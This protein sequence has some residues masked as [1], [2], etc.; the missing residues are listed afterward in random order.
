VD[1]G[2]E[3]KYYPRV[4]AKEDWHTVNVYREVLMVDSRKADPQKYPQSAFP[5]IHVVRVLKKGPYRYMLI[6]GLHRVRAFH[7]AKIAEI[8]AVVEHL[9][10]SKWF[11]RSVELNV[12]SKRG[13]DTGDKAYI[14]KRLETEGWEFKAIADLL[15]M[16]LESLE[17]IYVSRCHKLRVTK[18][19]KKGPE[20]RGKR[21]IDGDYYGFLKA[22]YAVAGLSGTSK[23][24]QALAVQGP[25]TSKDVMHILDSFLGLLEV[26]SLDM[27][28]PNVQ[29]RIERISSL[30]AVLV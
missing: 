21:K 11:A 3:P 27:S 22:P 15:E 10:E 14:A 23:A 4:S 25:V 5:P 30:L 7:A 8:C 26:G 19:V 13:F 20:H 24:T 18:I 16:R 9:P 12:A 1:I 2:Y 29:S 17:K 28:D 6:D